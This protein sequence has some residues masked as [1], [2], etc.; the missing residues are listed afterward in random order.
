MPRPRVQSQKGGDC[1]KELDE[2]ACWFDPLVESGMIAP[3][4][5]QPLRAECDEL[6]AIFTTKKAK[7]NPS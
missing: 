3:S 7:S 5:L 4:R 1:L 2:T 6:L